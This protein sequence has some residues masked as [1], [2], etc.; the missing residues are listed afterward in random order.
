[1]AKAIIIKCTIGGIDISNDS[2]DSLKVD[3]N[4]SD[5]SNKFS[6]SLVDSPA[7]NSLFTDI[8]LYMCS[9]G[10]TISFRYGDDINN[11]EAF[12][13]TIWDY[14]VTFV[15][16]IK[17]LEISGYV[18]PAVYIQNVSGSSYS[19]NIDWNNYYNLR[20]DNTK[21]WNALRQLDRSNGLSKKYATFK[22]KTSKTGELQV[23]YSGGMFAVYGT[24]EGSA[25]GEVQSSDILDSF[26]HSLFTFNTTFIPVHGPVGTIKLPVP[27]SF[28]T[29]NSTVVS[30]S[31]KDAGTEV[32]FKKQ[33][34][35]RFYGEKDLIYKYYNYNSHKWVKVPEDKLT[36]NKVYYIC[37][38]KHPDRIVGFLSQEGAYIEVNLEKKYAGAGTLLYNTNGVS[39][40]DIIRQLAILEGWE[41]GNIVDTDTVA[42][43]D[44]FKMH[45]Q[46][47]LDFILNNLVPVSILPI[48][49][50]KNSKGEDV[51]IPSGVGGF[52]PYFRD[53][54][55][56]YEPLNSSYYNDITSSLLLGYNIPNSPVLSFQIDTKGTVF[57]T[58]QP[59]K[60]S[61]TNI[62]TG[63]EYEEVST[64]SEAQINEYN[65][66][67]GFNE[68]LAS[69]FGYSF[70][71]AQSSGFKVT[72]S[73]TKSSVTLSGDSN[74]YATKDEPFTLT[75]PQLLI[76]SDFYSEKLVSSLAV[77][78]VSS[79]T[80]I[81]GRLE[82]SKSK[83]RDF[84]IKASMTL[85]GDVRLKPASLIK[86]VNMIKSSDNM[87][88]TEHFSSGVYM[89][90]SQSDE[91]SGAGFIQT[92]NLLKYTSDFKN[93]VEEMATI[94]W[95]TS[96]VLPITANLNFKEDANVVSGK[97]PKGYGLVNGA[98]YKGKYLVYSNG[99]SKLFVPDLNK[100]LDL[101]SL[102][103]DKSKETQK[104]VADVINNGGGSIKPPKGYVEVYP[105]IYGK[106]TDPDNV[107]S[108]TKFWVPF[109]G[110]M[111]LTW[112]K[113]TGKLLETK[114]LK[115][116]S[117]YSAFYVNGSSSKY[118][119]R[120]FYYKGSKP[121]SAGSYWLLGRGILERS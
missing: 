94:N 66:V 91:I 8:E 49:L 67:A 22:D 110:G 47:A 109:Y 62:V 74:P 77:S 112:K 95:R 14:R 105:D 42:C 107:E 13:G 81:K 41:I 111:Y 3:R 76:N 6:M 121:E 75:S 79:V 43:G 40:S 51:V 86:V 11:L 26:F 71:E 25:V 36:G 31:D 119:V 16:D 113:N 100:Y 89:I 72:A 46:T 30:G 12:N 17:K 87:Y 24:Y 96:K 28:V 2:I 19:Y 23:E 65:K 1:M 114:N 78:S 21:I 102:I 38:K 15:A 18:T 106:G 9:G 120:Y 101:N 54:K 27:T 37:T 82:N 116:P 98:K 45:N 4:F 29:S 32:D 92:L 108:I 118:T 59:L 99:T 5:V 69:F 33:A 56:Y 70:D 83:I 20:A 48:G 50:V 52:H 68:G 39:P 10:R 93:N 61:A 63:E 57:Y 7:V 44:T 84:M 55:F 60:L 97:L 90:Q 85:W 103:T 73:G 88:P 115:A 117:G 80:E 58:V 64:S 35:Y 53:G 34:V 104:F